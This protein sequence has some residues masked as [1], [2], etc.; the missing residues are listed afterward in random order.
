MKKCKQIFPYISIAVTILWSLYAFYTNLKNP[1]LTMM[2][3]FLDTYL[4]I[5][6]IFTLITVYF[7]Y[8]E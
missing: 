3:V 7:T 1:K 6:F 2:E 5:P 4:W 8:E